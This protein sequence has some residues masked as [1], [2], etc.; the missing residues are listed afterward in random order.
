MNEALRDVCAG[1]MAGMVCK[2]IEY[3]MD[4]VKVRLQ[5]ARCTYFGPKNCILR[6]F[7]EEG[8]LSFYRG[9]TAPLYGCMLETA[10]LFVVYNQLTRAFHQLKNKKNSDHATFLGTAASGFGAGVMVSIILTPIELVKCRMQV[11]DTLSQRQKKYKGSWHCAIQTLRNDGVKGLFRGFTSFAF[12]EAPGTALWYTVYEEMKVLLSGY[13][14]WSKVPLCDSAIAGAVAG[15]GYWTVF[16]PTDVVKTRIQV[17]N[18]Y[19]NHTLTRG[20]RDVYR[21][22]GVKELYK[23]WNITVARA[24][25]SHALLFLTYEFCSKKLEEFC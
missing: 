8:F 7:R 13:K 1:T 20:L 19:A 12:R 16:F 24:M 18:K 3:P 21:Q 11:E 10:I 2:A 5:D 6:M 9:L 14:L 23:G 17:D 22:G 4:T 25:P 15:F